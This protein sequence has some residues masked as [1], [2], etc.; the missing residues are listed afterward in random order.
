[1]KMKTLKSQKRSGFTLLEVVIS[2]A[3]L[4]CC[5]IPVVSFIPEALNCNQNALNKTAA[6]SVL[7]S[8]VSDLRSATPVT[9]GSTTT[10]RS[11]LFQFQIPQT[12]G[13]ASISSTST[14]QQAWVDASGAVVVANG[15]APT[16]AQMASS[17]FCVTVGFL[18]PTT[19]RV[20]TGARIMISWPPQASATSGVWPASYFGSMENTI[21]L[22]LN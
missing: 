2:L 16:T 8:V 14:P 13:T 21:Y 6:A 5:V 9:T 20:A 10:Y 11:P 15:S 7:A 22:D 3:I 19:G 17:S 12:G 1:M 4:A 18:P